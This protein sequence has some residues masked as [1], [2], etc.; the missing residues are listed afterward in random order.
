MTHFAEAQEL[1]VGREKRATIRAYDLLAAFAAQLKR[2]SPFGH[3][4][5]HDFSV[6]RVH[7]RER[8]I[9]LVSPI[10][11]IQTTI[12]INRRIEMQSKILRGPHYPMTEVGPNL[13]ERTSGT[14]T[15]RNKYSVVKD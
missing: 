9:R 5:P 6:C 4:T 10:E 3:F 13:E 2:L 11:S 12:P 7:A 15:C 1:A 14:I 8:G